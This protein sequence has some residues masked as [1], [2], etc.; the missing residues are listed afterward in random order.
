MLV[1]L[2]NIDNNKHVSFDFF[3]FAKEGTIQRA[4]FNDDIGSLQLLVIDVNERKN[5]KINVSWF[6][7]S[8]DFFFDNLNRT[9]VVLT[10]IRIVIK[11]NQLEVEKYIY[12]TCHTNVETKIID[13]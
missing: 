13:L 7:K 10:L 4:I 11:E 1:Y 9:E 12:G 5:Q 2:K 6:I 3:G 8:I